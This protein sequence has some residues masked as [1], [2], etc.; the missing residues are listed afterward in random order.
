MLAKLK[1]LTYLIIPGLFLFS[2]EEEFSIHNTLSEQEKAEGWELLF[3]GKSLNGWHLYHLGKVPS[4]WNA[5]DGELVCYPYSFEIEHGDLVTDRTFKNFDLV[6]EWKITEG[7]NSGVLINLQENDSARHSWHNG[8]E[9]QILDKKVIEERSYAKNP[10]RWSGTIYGLT[11]YPDNV[12]V[13]PTGEWN[14]GRIQQVEGRVSF[15]L[16][17]NISG[18]ADMNIEDWKETIEQSE[19]KNIPHFGKN[20]EGHIALQYWSKGVS[21]RNIKIKE[22]QDL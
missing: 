14:Q 6:F 15:W 1:L 7:G 20:T 16:N 12:E 5:K 10:T 19:F 3:D 17:G 8:I 13:K 21:F 9:Y 11:Q 22:L 2:C 18:E 4:N